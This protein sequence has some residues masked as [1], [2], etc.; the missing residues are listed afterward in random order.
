MNN[1]IKKHLKI[2]IV[3]CIIMVYNIHT[4]SSVEHLVGLFDWEGVKEPRTIYYSA[5]RR[6]TQAK[7]GKI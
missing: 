4:C 1:N 6:M 3:H 5:V 2:L 7:T